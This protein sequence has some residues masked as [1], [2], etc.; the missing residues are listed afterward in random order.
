[1][2]ERTDLDLDADDYNDADYI[3]EADYEDEIDEPAPAPA[4]APPRG[5]RAQRRQQARQKRPQ[6]VRA[7]ESPV[8]REAEAE[9]VGHDDDEYVDV[10]FDGPNGREIFTVPADPQ[11]WPGQVLYA[12]ENRQAMTAIEGLI[13]PNRWRS[14][15]LWRT[16]EINRLMETIAERGG[17]R[18]T[19]N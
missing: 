17:F 2:T 16:R 7:D 1:M 6:P 14:V 3:D 13:G 9:G 15:R 12:L 11:D 19:G 8:R 10:P 18:T 5:N 4:P